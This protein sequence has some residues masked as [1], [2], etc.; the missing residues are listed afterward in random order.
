MKALSRVDNHG[1]LGQKVNTPLARE[2]AAKERRRMKKLAETESLSGLTESA[3]VRR[4]PQ[5]DTGVFLSGRPRKHAERSPRASRWQWQ[6]RHR[7]DAARLAATKR[8]ERHRQSE[9]GKAKRKRGPEE[10]AYGRWV[11]FPKGSLTSPCNLILTLFLPL[12]QASSIEKRPFETSVFR[13]IC[14][15]SGAGTVS[16]AQPVLHPIIEYERTSRHAG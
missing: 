6:D 4:T 13:D 15:V 8:P 7:P 3:R 1:L 10:A 16:S 2:W 5:P 11:R 14:F 12:F 9:T